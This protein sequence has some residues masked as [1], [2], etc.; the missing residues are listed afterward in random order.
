MKRLATIALLLAALPAL[1]GKEPIENGELRTDLA[2]NGY[3][4]TGASN[5]T[6][7][8]NIATTNRV[9]AGAGFYYGAVFLNDTNITQS[10]TV[11]GTNW[12]FNASGLLMR[13][14]P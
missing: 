14:V 1:A 8:N 2:A 11:E 13:H 5:I 10:F 9:T 4:I 3:A 12:Q 6:A 7:T